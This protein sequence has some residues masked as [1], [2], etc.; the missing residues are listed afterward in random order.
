MNDAG[1]TTTPKP[2]E[3]PELIGHE[4]AEARFLSAW[5]SGRL[6]HGW[7]ITGPRGI[8]KATFAFRAARFV[9][10][11]GRSDETASL[12]G[13]EEPGNLFV[14]PD[15]P[16][17]RRIASGAHP[18]LTTLQRTINPDTGKLRTSIAVGDVR[19]AGDFM[20]LTAS[21]GG[22]RVVVVDSVDEMNV[23]AANA[24]L[25]ILEEPPDRA[26]LL[27][28]SHAPGRLLP[29]IRSR[30]CR[31]PLKL[32]ASNQVSELLA[33]QRPDLAEA[34]R[35]AIAQLADGSPGRAMALAEDDGLTLYREMMELLSGLPHPPV[36]ALHGYGDKLARNGAEEKFRTATDLLGWWLGRLA[37][38]GARGEGGPPPIVPEEE[39]LAGRM[40]AA[41]GVDRWMEVWEKTNRL[42]DDT[43]RLNLDRKQALLSMFHALQSAMKA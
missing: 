6:P 42:A 12:F 20:R 19:A 35:H 34:E 26:L 9:L 3:N 27:L 5:R 41:T 22:W 37:R 17:V 31:L 7:L 25:K 29:T 10:S 36:A 4:A 21:E 1:D 23:N 8:G 32:L 18:D 24:L 40:L 39:G 33:R 14:A 16:V 2:R 30:C 11:G 15:D 38:S 43:G 28:I 13:E